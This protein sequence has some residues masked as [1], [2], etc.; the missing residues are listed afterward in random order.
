MRGR[1]AMLWRCGRRRVDAGAAAAAVLAGAALGTGAP[2]ASTAGVAP[3]PRLLVTA[4]EWRLE[5]SRTTIDPGNA[6][7]Q[8][9]NQ[10]EDAHDLWI[11]RLHGTR[12]YK[13]PETLSGDVSEFTARLRPGRRYKLWCSLPAHEQLGM[14]ARLRVNEG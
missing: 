14:K 8:L 9:W 3:P 11:R 12:I 5:L 7:V 4:R 13:S 2:A 1:F 6:I 10:G